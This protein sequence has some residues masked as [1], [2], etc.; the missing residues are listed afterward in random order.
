MVTDTV[1]GISNAISSEV[2][3]ALITSNHPKEFLAVDQL[4]D[5]LIMI[6]EFN[7]DS[8]IEPGERLEYTAEESRYMHA[9]LQDLI[10]KQCIVLRDRPLEKTEF[11]F[12]SMVAFFDIWVNK[13]DGEKRPENIQY[14]L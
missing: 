7:I 3:I 8:E 14:S 4:S 2:I 12:N 5:E 10:S 9:K 6:N 1:D 13:L 11:N